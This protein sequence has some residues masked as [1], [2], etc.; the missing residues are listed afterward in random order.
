MPITEYRGILSDL[1]E[2]FLKKRVHII[3]PAINSLTIFN[4]F[5]HNIGGLENEQVTKLAEEV[6]TKNETG[7]LYPKLSLTIIPLSAFGNRNDFGNR[8]IINRHIDDCF[9]AETRYIKSSKMVFI[10]EKRHDFDHELAA[11]VLLENFADTKLM[12]EYLPE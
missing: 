4:V 7:T 2:E 3:C 10:F 1:R 8:I 12:V 9:E 11:T 6:N 5:A